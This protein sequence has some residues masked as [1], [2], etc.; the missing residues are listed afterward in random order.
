MGRDFVS[1]FDDR[2]ALLSH[3]VGAGAHDTEGQDP[4]RAGTREK[5]R[6]LD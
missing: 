3:S 6:D 5:G 4:G 1:R 2:L